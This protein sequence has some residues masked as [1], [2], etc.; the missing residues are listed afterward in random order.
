MKRNRTWKVH[1]KNLPDYITACQSRDTML[2][3]EEAYAGAYLTSHS[4]GPNDKPVKIKARPNGTFDIK[5]LVS[6][7]PAKHDQE[8]K[9]E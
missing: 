6:D 3:A 9:E 7:T 1:F 8:E 2:N 4:L 5:V